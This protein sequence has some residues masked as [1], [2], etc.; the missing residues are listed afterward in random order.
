MSSNDAR[1]NAAQDVDTEARLAR[2]RDVRNAM[3]T[4]ETVLRG[5]DAPGELRRRA[6]ATID[7]AYGTLR[8]RS[9]ASDARLTVMK[10]IDKVASSTTDAVDAGKAVLSRLP[11]ELLVHFE[12]HL[13]ALTGL[14]REWRN[15]RPGRGTGP[16]KWAAFAALWLVATGEATTADACKTMWTADRMKWEKAVMD[17]RAAGERQLAEAKK[18]EPAQT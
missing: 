13:E 4:A 3:T 15:R 14:V 10:A 7:A 11:P 2:A 16:R 8:G 12:A 6:E 18:A 17:A 9:V 1:R 5:L